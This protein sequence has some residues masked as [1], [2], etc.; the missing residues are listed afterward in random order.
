MSSPPPTDQGAPTAPGTSAPSASAATRPA[1][2]PAARVA[3]GVGLTVVDILRKVVVEPV[4]TGVIRP[5]GWPRGLLPIVVIAYIA[6]ATA[7]AIILLSGIL[8]GTPTSDP[9]SDPP[10]D[11]STADPTPATPDLLPAIVFALLITTVVLLWAGT[12]HTSAWTRWPVAAVAV[13]FTGG[14][15]NTDNLLH[16]AAITAIAGAALLLIYTAVRGGRRFRW[17]DVVAGAV[18][19]GVPAA[20]A[21]AMYG[22]PMNHAAYVAAML[23]LFA[24]PPI[25]A[26]GF[27]IAEVAVTSGVFVVST[28][29][30]RIGRVA[31]AVILVAVLAWRGWDI[32]VYTTIIAADPVAALWPLIGT[33][34]L[35]IAVGVLY[36]VTTRIRTATPA[37]V[38]SLSQALSGTALGLAAVAVAPYLLTGVL[39]LIRMVVASVGAWPS[40]LE[41]LARAAVYLSMGSTW[42]QWVTV[43]GIGIILVGILQARR[44]RTARAQAFIAVGAAYVAVGLP[45]WMGSRV[46]DIAARLAAIVAIIAVGIL[47]WALV[48]RR[49]DAT[50]MTAVTALL[51]AA[52]F[53]QHREIISDPV[54]LLLG[55][56]ILGTVIFGQIWGLI[57]GASNANRHTRRYPR[58]SRVLV[59]LGMTLLGLSVLAEQSIE[60]QDDYDVTVSA[61]SEVGV[62]IFGTAMFVGAVIVLIRAA[63]SGLALETTGAVEDPIP[64]PRAHVGDT[65]DRTV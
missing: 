28:V 29:A 6:N 31:V 42:M 24:L 54:G 33:V 38:K 39:L 65:P 27:G 60:P 20:V 2:H 22:D 4:Q 15:A 53:Y 10:A 17:W 46:G 48:T 7:L 61:L 49:L 19:I 30:A 45:I 51:L 3:R 25:F 55:S 64:N 23:M 56:A 1:R 12:L 5:R 44:G 62:T 58:P 13:M 40:L 8:R 9:T 32:A 35:I 52:A 43:S 50:R 47:L 36:R 57:T 18:M 41:P 63:I 34:A 37:N 11:L 26:A 14:I 16:P 21:D 59:T